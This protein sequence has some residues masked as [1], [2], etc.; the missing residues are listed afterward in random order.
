[1]HST[2]STKESM[3]RALL[4]HAKQRFDAMKSSHE[5]D[6]M[7]QQQIS[8][9]L[10]APISPTPNIIIETFLPRLNIDRN[11]LLVDLGCG[12][13]RWLLAANSFTNCRCLGIDV[14]ED[15]LTIAQNEIMK[16]KL[17]DA[18]QVRRQDVFQFVKESEDVLVADVIVL[19]L[20]R[21]AM[22]AMGPLLRQRLGERKESIS[23]KS[24]QILSVGFALAGWAS[25]YEQKIGGVRV[26]LY[27]T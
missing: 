16:L 19:Y 17:Q 21:E 20:F 24:V 13:G 5:Q 22:A 10:A 18:V 23:P 6:S 4:R 9:H 14:D 2:L 8:S 7:D 11:S 27:E 3:K 15:R 25:A 12:D 1:M 26:Y